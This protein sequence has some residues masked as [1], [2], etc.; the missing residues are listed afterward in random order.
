M[1][2][3]ED[4][5]LDELIA[6]GQLDELVQKEYVDKEMMTQY[7]KHLFPWKLLFQWLNHGVIPSNDFTHREFAFTLQNDA[8]LRYL[9]FPTF[10]DLKKEAVQMTP[11]RFEIGPV[12]SANP[13]DRKTLKKASFKPLEKEL[14]FDI[15]MTD[16][17]D[18]RTCCSKANVCPKC[19][20]FMTVAMK[21]L[22]TTFREDFGFEHI[23]WV[24]SGRRGIHAW[25]CDEKARQLD[26]R[27]R[28]MIAGYL[29][30]VVGDVQGGVRVNGLK[31]PLHPFISRSLELLSE[32]FAQTIL[33]EQDPWRS[34]EGAERLL[35]ALPDKGLVA[36]LRKKWSVDLE[37]PSISKWADIDSVASAGVSKTLDPVT[38]KN[39]KQDIVL[40][41]MYPRLDVEVSKHLNHLLKSP[42]CVHPGTGRICVPIRMEDA[43]SFNP[44]E[45]PVL[46]TLLQELDEKGDVEKT[47]LNSYISHFRGFCNQL[48][49]ETSRK[50][51]KQGDMTF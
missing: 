10:D 41:Y 32:S 51:R 2:G 13:R 31:R 8:Y 29:Q 6:S 12:Y 48:L 34:E 4:E 17:D 9:S 23:L 26:D 27:G 16:Y 43:G 46:Q 28:R 50:K 44:L 3:E 21:V 36:A 19:W 7:Y 15:D 24:Y 37:R 1:D 25:I 18:V 35:K 38:L 47:S 5:N 14:V 20:L 49:A 40:S 33:R 45:V 30:V 22:D 39:A 11:S 42:F